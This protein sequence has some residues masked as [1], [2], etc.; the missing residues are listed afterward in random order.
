VISLVRRLLDD[1]PSPAHLTALRV[2]AHALVVSEGMIRAMLPGAEPEPLFAWLSELPFVRLGPSGVTLDGPL[3]EVVGADFRW[4]DPQR[5]GELHA[6]LGAYLLEQVRNAPEARLDHGRVGLSDTMAAQRGGV[7]TVGAG[8]NMSE[9]LRPLRRTIRGAR[10]AVFAFSQVEDLAEEWAATPDRPRLAMAFDRPDRGI[11]RRPI[12][13]PAIAQP[14]E[15][16]P[17]RYSSTT[18]PCAAKR[19]PDTVQAA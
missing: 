19:R 2:A 10:V 15:V 9:T 13:L 5:Y 14:R 1:V 4:H 17:G 16:T 3:D 11:E 6:R 12:G 8:R 18:T 7:A